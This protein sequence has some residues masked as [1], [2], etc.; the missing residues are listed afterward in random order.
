MVPS[1]TTVVICSCQ[2]I[3]S[4]RGSWDRQNYVNGPVFRPVV[5]SNLTLQNDSCCQKSDVCKRQFL[6]SQSM[7]ILC[8]AWQLEEKENPFSRLHAE[9]SQPIT[10][11]NLIQSAYQLF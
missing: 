6:L 5:S 10:G 2:R 4:L 11:M 3:I 9:C 1:L 8:Q 7:D